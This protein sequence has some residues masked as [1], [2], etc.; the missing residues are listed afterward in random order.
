MANGGARPGAGRPKGSLSEASR[1]IRDALEPHRQLIV[2]QLL[3]TL[4][5]PE[6]PAYPK[7]LEL[8]LAYGFCRPPQPIVGDADNPLQTVQRVERVIVRPKSK[9]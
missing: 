7:A 9:K 3:A 4:M 6:H 5:S 2:G 1:W 8:S